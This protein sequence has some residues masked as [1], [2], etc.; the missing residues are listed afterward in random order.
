MPGVL[1]G[2]ARTGRAELSKRQRTPDA[3]VT[4]F[5]TTARVQSCPAPFLEFVDRAHELG[6]TDSKGVE[7]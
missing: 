1:A 2:S 4:R 7:A 3:I 6:G 5:P